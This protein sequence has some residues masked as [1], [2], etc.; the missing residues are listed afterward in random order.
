MENLDFQP[1]FTPLETGLD[2]FIDWKKKFIGN[3][4]IIDKK[5]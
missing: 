5:K 4:H 2:K 3:E 1:D